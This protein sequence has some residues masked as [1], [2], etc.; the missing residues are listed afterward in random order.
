MKPRRA[1]AALVSS[2][3]LCLG[4]SSLLAL[5]CGGSEGNAT[6]PSND[7]GEAPDFTL[8]SLDGQTV[9]LSDY[10]G[11]KVVLINFWSTTCDPCMVEMPHL[12]ELYKKHKDKGFEVLAISLDGPETLSLVPSAVKQKEMIF[13]V[14]LDEETSVVTRYNPKR[15]MPFNVVVDK[16]GNVVFKRSSYTAGDEV[17][18][19]AAVEKAL[20]VSP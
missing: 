9:T 6:T 14:L 3:A 17:T 19:A 5:G 11:K 4:A 12:V 2:A 13:P 16:A 15:D 18:L 8:K 10:R 20:G 7:Q 1:F